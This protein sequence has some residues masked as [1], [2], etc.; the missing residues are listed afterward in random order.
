MRGR[1]WST[2]RLNVTANAQNT[3]QH[4]PLANACGAHV[5]MHKCVWKS[6]PNRAYCLSLT[7]PLKLKF[8][9]TTRIEL[10]IL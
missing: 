2:E 6:P 9:I 3:L 8:L 1:P 5:N 4:S 7:T 10:T